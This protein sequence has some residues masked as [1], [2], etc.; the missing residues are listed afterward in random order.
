L[1]YPEEDDLDI[2]CQDEDDEDDYWEEWEEDDDDDDEC[3]DFD[4]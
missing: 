1:A 3:S 2:V 4:E